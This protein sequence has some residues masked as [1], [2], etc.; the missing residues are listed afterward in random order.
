M[1]KKILPPSYFYIAAI[2]MILSHFIFLTATIIDTPWNYL[3][4]I[5]A[6]IGIVL[7]LIAD[8]DFKLHGTTVK[9]FQEPT[10]LMTNGVF[11]ISR[12]PMYLGFVL[13]LVG[14]AI[15]LGTLTPFAIIIVFTILMDILYIR[16]EEKMLEDKF[17]KTW[18]AYKRGV[19]KWI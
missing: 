1:S 18:L 14:I 17:G 6:L 11:K 2:L 9:P 3:G 15:F 5:P 13:I 7:N 8:K 10:V 4:A 19:R 16:V 12:N